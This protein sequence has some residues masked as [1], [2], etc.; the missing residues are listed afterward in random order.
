M[1]KTDDLTIE[2]LWAHAQAQSHQLDE[3]KNSNIDFI[4]LTQ[5]ELLNGKQLRHEDYVYNFKISNIGQI[6]NVDSDILKIKHLYTR[7]TTQANF[8]GANLTVSLVSIEG[9]LFWSLIY[10][11]KL[12]SEKFMNALGNEIQA[13]INKLIIS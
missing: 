9:R 7:T 11:D 13:I 5:P 12:I 3:I 4:F 2:T 1:P 10:N 6:Q 8:S